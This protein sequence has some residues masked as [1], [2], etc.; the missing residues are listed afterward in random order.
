MNITR[1]EIIEKINSN[2]TKWFYQLYNGDCAKEVRSEFDIVYDQ[3][4][5]DGNDYFVAFQFPNLKLFVLLE[6]SYS[7][8][9]SPDWYKV[10]FA[11]PFEYKETRYKAVTLE[12]IRDQKIETV[13]E[14]DKKQD[15]V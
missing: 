9:D 10:S 15:N 8:Y 4:W 14:D 7:S 3:H 11:Q 6:G 5:G 13:L 2:N 1:D 12:Y